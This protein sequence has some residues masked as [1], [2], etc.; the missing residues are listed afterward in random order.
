MPDS[1]GRSFSDRWIAFCNRD[2]EMR[3]KRLPRPTLARVCDL[4]IFSVDLNSIASIPKTELVL[5]EWW[6]VLTVTRVVPVR[7]FLGRRLWCYPHWLLIWTMLRSRTI[8]LHQ[9][10]QRF[11]PLKDTH[12]III[13]K[14]S[15]FQNQKMWFYF[16]HRLDFDVKI[17]YN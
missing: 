17:F 13:A 12:K 3:L 6:K 15:T 8:F 9:F 4:K 2:N 14:T 7:V 5:E 10:C 11:P 1:T 16:F